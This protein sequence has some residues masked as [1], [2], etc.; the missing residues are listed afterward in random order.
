MKIDSKSEFIR[1]VVENVMLPVRHQVIHTT[2]SDLLSIW[3]FSANF[4]DICELHINWKD[5][6]S[7][8]IGH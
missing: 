4:I 7:P 1:L 3:T 8:S 2:Y 5:T 6:P